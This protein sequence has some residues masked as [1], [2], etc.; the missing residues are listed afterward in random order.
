MRYFEKMAEICKN[1]MR[2][3]ENSAAIY[4]I[5]GA[6]AGPRGD[7]ALSHSWRLERLTFRWKAIT[8]RRA[9]ECQGRWQSQIGIGIIG[10]VRGDSG[11]TV[12]TN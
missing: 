1:A 10:H 12:M 3:F 2:Y 5:F 4:V 6:G 11:Y 8:V 7:S 9:R